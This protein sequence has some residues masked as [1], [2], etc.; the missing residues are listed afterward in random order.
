VFDGKNPPYS[1]NSETNPLN[2]YGKTCREGEQIMWKNQSDGVRYN[3]AKIPIQFR[4]YSV[5]LMCLEW[6]SVKMVLLQNS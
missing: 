3:V 6:E 2:V 1:S 5:L 4:V